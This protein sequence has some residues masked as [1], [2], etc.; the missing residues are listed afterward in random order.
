MLGRTAAAGR[1][2]CLRRDPCCGLAPTTV[3]QERVTMRR[4]AVTKAAQ[5]R[6]P[7]QNAGI[8]VE[9]RHFDQSRAMC[10]P[11]SLRIVLEYF[12]TQVSENL[13]AKACRSSPVTGT[14]G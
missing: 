2:S 14:T 9:T 7:G 6:S 5:K 3:S 11:A 13:V 1:M 4:A 8:R 10:G 12:G